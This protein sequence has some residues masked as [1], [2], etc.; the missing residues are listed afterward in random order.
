[1]PQ[2]SPNLGG[3]M[4]SALTGANCGGGLFGSNTAQD[5]GS[6]VTGNAGFANTPSSISG[7]N[8][9]DPKFLQSRA[10]K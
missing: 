2:P 4:F 5:F 6:Q 10:K 7:L 1:M 3:G 9:T 8:F